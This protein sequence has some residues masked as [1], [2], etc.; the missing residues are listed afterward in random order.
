MRKDGVQ[1]RFGVQS[2]SITVEEKEGQKEIEDI[3]DGKT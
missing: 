2:K 1:I 3:L